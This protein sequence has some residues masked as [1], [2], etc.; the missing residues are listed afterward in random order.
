MQTLTRLRRQNRRAKYSKSEDALNCQVMLKKSDAE[1]FKL[2]KFNKAADN[3]GRRRW[4]AA[5]LTTL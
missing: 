2:G 3:T 4:K 1:R 5:R